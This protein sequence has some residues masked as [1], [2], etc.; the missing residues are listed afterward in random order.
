M[1]PGMLAPLLNQVKRSPP[2]SSLVIFDLDSTLY[3]LTQRVTAILK[4]FTLDPEVCAKFPEACARLQ[5]VKIHRT[6]WGLVEPLSRVGITNS[7]HDEFVREVHAAWAAGFFSNDFLDRDFPLPGAVEF[8]RA[9]LERGAEILYL[10]GRDV[11]RMGAGTQ[12][13]LREW[14]FPLEHPKVN[15]V[16]KPTK[17]LD[18][19]QFKADVIDALVHRYDH[20]WL[21]ENEPV[22]INVVLKRTP[23]V[24]VVFVDTCHS[25]LEVVTNPFASVE[26]F[27]FSISDLE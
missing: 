26:H 23:K 4:R 22:N 20:V 7:S 25:G 10:T 24:K 8:V 3:D 16:L 17:E 6:D 5:N 11:P 1:V 12:T 15:L 13:S 2:G 21:F 19:A 14:G 9:C 18:D 27:D